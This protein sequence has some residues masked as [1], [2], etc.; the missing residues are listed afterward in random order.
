M[1]FDE[2]YIE[3]YNNFINS[4]VD[5]RVD[6]LISQ[7]NI[8]YN[9]KVEDKYIFLDRL[10]DDY[11]ILEKIKEMI[12]T[13]FDYKILVPVI[14]KDIEL[15]LLKKIDEM[16]LD[17]FILFIKINN[18]KDIIDLINA[19]EL[20]VDIN[21]KIKNKINNNLVM[22]LFLNKPIVCNKSEINY[23]LLGEYPY[24]YNSHISIDSIIKNK[25]AL[26]ADRESVIRN[27]L[28]LSIL[29]EK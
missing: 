24:Y 19:A 9:F 13:E 14:N 18:I 21:T 5:N 11:N 27:Y 12:I 2:L 25:K 22:A 15:N 6:K 10:F 28:E 4:G 3:F 26:L 20:V 8:N 23:K 29:G 1:C 16:G 7:T 17:E